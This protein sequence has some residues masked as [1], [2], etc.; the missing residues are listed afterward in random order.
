MTKI[1]I[2]E[3][4]K[5]LRSQKGL[6]QEQMGDALH[7][8]RSSYANYENGIRLPSLELAC[9]MADYFQIPLRKLIFGLEDF[10]ELI[11]NFPSE[12]HEFLKAYIQLPSDAQKELLEHVKIMKKYR[13][14]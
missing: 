14:I 8:S 6:N 10:E 2:G 7:I 3:T 11:E 5:T 4:L 12:Y 9:E 1:K 13:K